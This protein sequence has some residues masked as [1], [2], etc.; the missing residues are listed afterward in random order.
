MAGPFRRN[1]LANGPRTFEKSGWVPPLGP[2]CQGAA[3]V[4][5]PGRGTKQP[6]SVSRKRPTAFIATKGWPNNKGH[7]L[8]GPKV[9]FEDIVDLP[10][11]YAAEIHHGT[12]LVARAMK[13]G[14]GCQGISTW[15][16]NKPSAIKTSGTITGYL[17]DDLCLKV[18][19]ATEPADRE[20]YADRLRDRLGSHR[21]TLTEITKTM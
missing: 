2:L 15:H 10:A 16:H 14:Y 12:Q 19:S 8:L 6:D 4:D 17:G 11:H 18:G 5:R 1:E 13:C 21:D 7:V 3:G 9:H 20:P